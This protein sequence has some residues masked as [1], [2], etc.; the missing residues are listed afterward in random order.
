VIEIARV[1]A[2]STV[3]PELFFERWC[4]LATHPEWAPGMDYLRLDEPFA[5]G[6]RGELKVSGENPRPFEVTAIE[7]GRLYADTTVLEGARLT[8]SHEALPLGKGSG[9]ALEIVCTV[10]GERAQHYADEFTGIGDAL[11]GDLNR[12]VQ[13]LE[14]G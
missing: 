7:P 3:A 13:L 1:S 11:Q 2:T 4:D 14:R 6:A 12:L 5:V 8:V 9:S 10:E